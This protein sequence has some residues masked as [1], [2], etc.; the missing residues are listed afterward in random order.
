M[1]IWLRSALA[2]AILLAIP[3]LFPIILRAVNPQRAR[4]AIAQGA[5]RQRRVGG[6]A[7]VLA[8]GEPAR[9][10]ALPPASPPARSDAIQRRGLRWWCGTLA[11]VTLLGTVSRTRRLARASRASRA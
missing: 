10:V 4:T 2:I 5:E 1:A 11:A 8:S 9:A 7:I 3:I 6:E